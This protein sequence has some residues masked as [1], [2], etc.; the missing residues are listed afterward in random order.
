MELTKR[1]HGSVN[2][3][4]SLKLPVEGKEKI[5]IYQK[6]DKPETIS[7]VYWILNINSYILTTGQLL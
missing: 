6:D 1:V 7:D 2:L 5:K 3:G 4:D